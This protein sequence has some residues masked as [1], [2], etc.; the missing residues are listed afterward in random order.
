MREQN[1]KNGFRGS[2]V[3]MLLAAA[4]LFAAC[5]GGGGSGTSPA[6]NAD[7]TATSETAS[8]SASAPESPAQP[9]EET[10]VFDLFID[11]TWWPYK[12]WSGLIPE[13]VTRQTGVSF[14][15]TVATDSNQ[16]PL[17]IA[18]GDLPDMVLTPDAVNIGR[19]SNPQLS[20]AYNE[21]IG[22]YAP[23]FVIDPDRTLLNTAADGN[24]YAI[25]SLYS[26]KEEYAKYPNAANLA[27]GITVRK[28]IMEALGNPPLTS[29]DDLL[30]VYAM[31]KE[32]YPDIVPVVFNTN[33]THLTQYFFAQF[34]VRHT[35][36][37]GVDGKVVHWLNQPNTLQAYLFMNKLYREGYA[38]GENFAWKDHGEEIAMMSTGKAFSIPLSAG[39]SSYWADQAKGEAITFMDPVELFNDTYKQF[40]YGSGAHAV[41]ITKNNKNPE[42]AIQFMQWAHT[43]EAQKLLTWGIEGQHWAW[44]PEG[45]IDWKEPLDI[46][47]D[48]RNGYQA[49][50]W[51]F[52]FSASKVIQNLVDMRPGTPGAIISATV[53]QKYTVSDP[54]IAAIKVVPDS[55]ESIIEAEINN[56]VQLEQIKV[57]L[58]ETEEEATAAFR[59]MMAKA[60]QIGIKKYEEYWNA[61]YE[62]VKSEQ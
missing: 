14:N 26:T 37:A 22:Q 20:Y 51:G 19:L 13:E 49:I 9:A 42:K 6:D 35:G 30:N 8:P 54:V 59:D 45:Y 40:N 3:F 24:I 16:L 15:V 21:L 7:N 44:N 11:P 17:M 48:L 41:F 36:V 55:E 47:A 32:R 60:E 56:M 2:F 27:R 5:S 23:G 1:R 61:Q 62:K 33:L 12:T 39:A 52:A 58:A 10:V 31:V 50:E 34:G 28:D 4:V 25:R 46:D 18:S 38:L 57:F 43:E 29:T 53:S